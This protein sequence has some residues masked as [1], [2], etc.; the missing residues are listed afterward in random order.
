MDICVSVAKHEAAA[1][2]RKEANGYRTVGNR[3][4]MTS[5]ESL[6]ASQN[7]LEAAEK[8]DSAATHLILSTM[9]D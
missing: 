7:L 3:L 5:E 4:P 6:K 8:L 1:Q 9:T 2:L